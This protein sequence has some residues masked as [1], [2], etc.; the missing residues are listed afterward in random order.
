MGWHRMKLAIQGE[1]GSFSHEAAETML[2]RAEIVP[3]A[4]S[5]E[6]FDR[7]QRQSVD[8]AVIFAGRAA[9]GGGGLCQP[10]RSYRPRVPPAHRPQPDRS[11]RLQ[12]SRRTASLLASGGPRSMPRPLRQK[13]QAGASSLLRHRRQREARCSR[14]LARCRR[15]RHPE[16]RPSLQRKNSEGRRRRRQEELYAFLSNQARKAA[17]RARC[18]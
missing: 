1:L 11:A 4:R 7:V 3:C 5:L 2:P 13:S 16:S 15:N 12:A 18:Q 8:G 9:A 17:G 6:V 10:R 14:G